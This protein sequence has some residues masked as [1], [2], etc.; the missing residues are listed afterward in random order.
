MT[1]PMT[2]DSDYGVWTVTGTTAW[3]GQYYLFEVEVYVH[4]TGEVERNVVTDPY[5]VSLSMNSH[6][7]QIVDLMDPALMPDGWDTLVK[8]AFG[9]TGGHFCV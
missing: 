7:S 2:L 8:T 3:E 9:C 6:R 4:S 1:M 5:A